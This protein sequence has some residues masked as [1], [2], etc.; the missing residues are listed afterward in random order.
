MTIADLLKECPYEKIKEKFVLHYGG[1]KLR[2]F[3][4]LYNW[5]TILEPSENPDRRLYISI[6]AYDMEGHE[7]EHFDE[8]NPDVDFDVY[9]YEKKNK[10]EIYSIAAASYMDFAASI[11]DDDTMKRYSPENI[12]A[13]CFLEITSCPPE[14]DDKRHN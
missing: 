3:K 4:S 11:V 14:T 10:K 9:A 8:N 7:L 2:E 5:M 1:E 12:L 6:T 13:H